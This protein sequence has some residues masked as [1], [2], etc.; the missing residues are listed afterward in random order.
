MCNQLLTGLHLSKKPRS[1]GAS[2][3]ESEGFEPPVELPLLQFSR[4]PQSALGSSVFAGLL[5]PS[6]LCAT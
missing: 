2:V 5:V 3:A 6:R 4:P 1:N